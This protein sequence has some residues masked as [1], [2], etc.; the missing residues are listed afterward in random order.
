M[1]PRIRRLT[2]FRSI[3]KERRSQSKHDNNPPQS[4]LTW[5]SPAQTIRRSRIS[6]RCGN[7]VDSLQIQ[8]NLQLFNKSGGQ[9]GANEYRFQAAHG[10][11][12]VGFHGKAGNFIDAVGV[13]VRNRLD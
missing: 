1:I 2:W 12:F 5:A 7:F 10:E 6:G 13:M 8:T 3:Q 11:E 9:G 4:S